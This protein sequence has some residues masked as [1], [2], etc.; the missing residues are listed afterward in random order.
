MQ[1]D[2]YTKLFSKGNK[3]TYS[4]TLLPKLIKFYAFFVGV[5]LSKFNNG[6][7]RKCSLNYSRKKK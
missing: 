3:K 6:L 7:V 4:Q 1:S 2:A 5:H